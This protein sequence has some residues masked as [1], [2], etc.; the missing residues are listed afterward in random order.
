MRWKTFASLL[1]FAGGLAVVAATA[2]DDDEDGGTG[3]DVETFVA[4]LTVAAEV[5]PVT[6]P[7]NASGRATLEFG[8]STVDYLIEVDDITNVIFAHIHLGPAGVAGPI[9]VFL[10]EQAPP[11][12][13]PLDDAVLVEASFDAGDIEGLGDDPPI[14]L[15]SLRTLVANGEAYVNVHTV[16]NPS[17]EIR[18]QTREE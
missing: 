17:G 6:T 12:S 16:Q 4:D 7:S 1:A 2:C 13:G 10:F 18:G 15:D 8:A 14:S 11:G 9:L 3:P 5:P